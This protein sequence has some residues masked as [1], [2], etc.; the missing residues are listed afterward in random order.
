MK[1]KKQKLKE[2]EY[3]FIVRFKKK[4]SKKEINKI[5]ELMLKQKGVDNIMGAI[6]LK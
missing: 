1:P 3:G 2:R 6:T 4:I 5:I